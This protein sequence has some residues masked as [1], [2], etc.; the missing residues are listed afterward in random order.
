[1]EAFPKI[2]PRH[3][4][5]FAGQLQFEQGGEDFGGRQLVFQALDGFVDV[6]GLIGFQQ[7]P[8]FALPEERPS[9]GNRDAE[10]ASADSG[11]SSG[12]KARCTC[13]ARSSHASF[14]V[15]NQLGALFDQYVHPP[16]ILVSDV[17][18][19]GENVP[20]LFPRATSN[21][22]A[23]WCQG[24]A[25]PRHVSHRFAKIVERY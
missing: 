4:L 21:Y 10:Q 5:D 6:R 17:A 13:C 14:Q 2:L 19:H 25:S 15:G 3:L 24:H 8:K 23:E 11:K 1:L 20:I 18:R 9:S 7:A 22:P 12:V 16:G